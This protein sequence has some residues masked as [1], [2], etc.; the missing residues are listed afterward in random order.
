M[1]PKANHV[2]DMPAYPEIWDLK[3]FCRVSCLKPCAAVNVIYRA[4]KAGTVIR[5]KRG[6]NASPAL[7]QRAALVLTPAPLWSTR[8]VNSVFNLAASHDNRD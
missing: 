4:V 2:E 7:Y 5:V 3:Y 1:N 8:M 6:G